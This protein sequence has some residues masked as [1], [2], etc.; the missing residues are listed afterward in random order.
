MQSADVR[1][2]A[3]ITFALPS[4]ASPVAPDAEEENDDSRDSVAS[5]PWL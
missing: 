2:R 4:D 3:T 5:A 1:L